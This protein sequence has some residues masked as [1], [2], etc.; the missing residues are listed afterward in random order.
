M[1]ETTTVLE[2]SGL[3]MD[4]VLNTFEDILVFFRKII[5]FLKDLIKPLL[6]GALDAV[7]GAI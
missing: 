7:K 2:E 5:D 1:D 3:D 4:G 6:S